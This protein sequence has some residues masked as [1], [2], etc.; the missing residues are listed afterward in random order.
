MLT[1]ADRKKQKQLFVTLTEASYTNAV[2]AVDAYRTPLPAEA[3]TYELLKLQPAAKQPDITNLFRFAELLTL[4]AQA[5]DDAHDLAYEDVNATQAIGAG[6]YRRPIEDLRTRY[7][8]ND[9]SQ[10]LP[11]RTLQALALP[12]ESYKL[13][14][15]PGLLSTVYQRPH[16]GQPAEN[17]L[18]NPSAVLLADA[19]LASDRGGYMDLDGDGRWWISSGRVFFHPDENVIATN[20]LMEAID[21]FFLPRR[22]RNTFSR[23]TFV[24]YANDLFP[25]K[26]RDTLGNTVEARR[27]QEPTTTVNV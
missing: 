17:L 16:A 9:L 19:S 24:D 4:V 8:S 27:I 26:T 1:S 2:L 18:P 10:L 20:E 12:G 23:S 25:V 5:S 3:Q 21:H 15:T 14:F 6:P 7:R 11:L 22:F 13:A